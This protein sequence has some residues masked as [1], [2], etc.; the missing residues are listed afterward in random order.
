MT[1]RLL[2]VLATP[3]DHDRDLSRVQR[4]G[5][6]C[7]ALPHVL[8]Y[9]VRPERALRDGAPQS[10]QRDFLFISNEIDVIQ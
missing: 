7:A 10:Q 9:L 4:P 8:R 3:Y 6:G 5:P 2:D 1:E